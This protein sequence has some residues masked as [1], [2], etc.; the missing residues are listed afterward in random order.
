MKEQL[1]ELTVAI[2]EGIGEDAAFPTDAVFPLL[3][4]SL[5]ASGAVLQRV[6]WLTGRTSIVLHNH[7]QVWLPRLSEATRMLRHT[8]PLLVAIAQG[9]LSPATAQQAAGGSLS[10]QASPSRAFLAEL[11]HRPQLVS[12]GLRGGSREVLGMAFSR[13]GRDFSGH[14]LALLREVQP[15]LQALDRHLT[16]VQRWRSAL[17]GTESGAP[18]AAADAGLTNRQV[19]VLVLLAQGLTATAAARRLHC[20]PRTVNNHTATIFHK[21]GV[22]DRLAAVLEAQRRGLVPATLGRPGRD[23]APAR[24]RRAESVA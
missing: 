13:S 2:F 8:H 21:L 24:R 20:S 4:E 11:V 3:C 15:V 7:P 12:V 23:E 6:D 1:V 16:R 18:S 10:W 17:G 5:D 9:D 14:H 22:H 19:E